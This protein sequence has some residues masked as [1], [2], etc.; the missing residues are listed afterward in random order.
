ME[1]Y[2]ATIR[3]WGPG[4][5]PSGWMACEGQL[6]NI[7]QNQA[8]YSLLA[9]RYGGDGRTTFALPDLRGRFPKCYAPAGGENLGSTGGVESVKLSTE[10]I[11]VH[12]HNVSIVVKE[13][14]T[15]TGANSPSPLNACKGIFSQ[16]ST[17][18]YSDTPSSAAY[19]GAL[20]VEFT[21]ANAGG[22]VEH[23]NL[24]PYQAV[25]YIICVQGLY[26]TRS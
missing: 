13:E 24:H 25:R 18:V 22:D 19:S 14:C 4:M 8:L 10:Q 12:K 9:N 15:N 26:P 6:L 21:E 23:T 11:P 17:L 5:I 20:H 3:P 16:G 7:V 1:D 2:L